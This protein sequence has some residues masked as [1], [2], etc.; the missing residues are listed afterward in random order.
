MTK[1]YTYC[2][3]CDDGA[4]PNPFWGTCTL[5]ICKPAIRRTAEIG[6]WIVGTG[7]KH[8]PI[9]DI[10]NK[11]VYAM[12]VS[13][14]MTM[15]EYDTW[16]AATLPEKISDTNNPDVRRKLGDSIYDFS[17]TPPTQR[18]GV[19]GLGNRPTDLRGLNALLSDHFFYFGDV[20]QQLPPNLLGI[21]HHTQGHRVRL[22]EPFVTEFIE[23]LN[24]L[25]LKAK[26]LYGKPALEIFDTTNPCGGACT[27]LEA[28]EA[29]AH[30]SPC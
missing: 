23:W 4:A 14:V 24:R 20:P 1:L 19:H 11:M 25:H 18:V 27:R 7:S 12:R 17:T 3:P 21:V 16:T 15:Q 28:A 10:S 2:I 9:G 29:D 30:V 22:N 13:K 5:T 6:D 26:H 8:S